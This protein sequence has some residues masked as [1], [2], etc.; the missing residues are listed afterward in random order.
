MIDEGYD[1][2]GVVEVDDYELNDD[3]R[4]TWYLVSGERVR[5]RSSLV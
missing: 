3:D 2:D 4:G 5:I 1:D